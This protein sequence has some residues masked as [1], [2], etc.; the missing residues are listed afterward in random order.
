MSTKEVAKSGPEVARGRWFDRFFDWPEWP[1]FFRGS[2]WPGTEHQFRVEEEVTDTEMVVKAE[3]PG[4]DPDRD[5]EISVSDGVLRIHVE[6]RQEEKTE[7]KGRS[8]S[9]FRY[10]SYT[11]S[12]LLPPGADQLDVKATYRDG[13]LEVHVPIAKEKAT[14]AKI[15]ISRG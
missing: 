7:E 5:A 8:R 15:P 12:I 1:E 9:E 6:R 2:P 14:A 3:V 4:I 11:R 10:G 13:I